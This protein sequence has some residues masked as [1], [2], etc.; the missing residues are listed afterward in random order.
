MLNNLL[1]RT[2]SVLGSLL[3]IC[4]LLAIL[5]IGYKSRNLLLVGCFSGVMAWILAWL[6]GQEKIPSW[7]GLAFTLC[8]TIIF[9][10]RALA[11]FWALVG[12]IQHQPNYDAK[13][14]CTLIILLL[15]MAF[16]SLNALI[17]AFVFQTADPRKTQQ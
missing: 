11:N 1:A 2:L 4:G 13:N 5:T 6:I 3:I 8:A 12:I 16:V 7:A 14:K 10:Q 15:V 17:L 9:T